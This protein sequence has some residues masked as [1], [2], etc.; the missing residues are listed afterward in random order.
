MA[1]TI[2]TIS[3]PY[4]L[5]DRWCSVSKVALDNSYPTGGYALLPSSLGFSNAANNDP[6]MN[7]EVDSANGWGAVYNYATQKLQLFTSTGTTSTEVTAATNVSAATPRV[8]CVSKMA[9][10]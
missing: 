8:V 9:P 10:N 4:S 5:G 7:I 3:K 2:T 6:E 1:L